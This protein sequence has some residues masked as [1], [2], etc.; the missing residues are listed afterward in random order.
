MKYKNNVIAWGREIGHRHRD[1]SKSN[2]G[3][4]RRS[5]GRII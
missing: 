2:T 1:T 5:V 3:K 4:T